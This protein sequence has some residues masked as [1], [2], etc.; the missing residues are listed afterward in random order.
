MSGLRRPRRPLA[1]VGVVLITALAVVPSALAAVK[2]GGVDS[3]NFPSLRVTVVT[4]KGSK[5][6]TLLE[7]GQPV[8]GASAVNLGQA[9]TVVVAIDRSESMKGRPISNAVAAAQQFVRTAGPQDHIGVVEFGRSAITVQGASGSAADAATSLQSVTVDTKSGTS[10]Y[11]AVVMSANLLKQDA[12]A[13]RAII[14][15]T[16]GADVSSLHTLADAVAA[17]HRAHASIYSIGIGGPSFTPDALRSLAN[18]T[19]GSYRQAANSAAL[20]SVYASLTDEL[21]RTWQITYP[22]AA[23]PGSRVELTASVKGGG[24]ST[25]TVTL[26]GKSAAPPTQASPVIPSAGYSRLGTLLVSL[27]VAVLVFLAHRAWMAAREGHWLGRRLEPHLMTSASSAEKRSK[28]SGES[29]RKRLSDTIEA[30]FANVKQ[31]RALQKKIER[32]NIQWR[33]GELLAF[34]VGIGF[35][36]GLVF[37]VMFASP[38]LGLVGI[39]AGFFVPI[40]VVTFK[41][42]SRLKKFENQLPD[43]LITMAASLKAGHSFRQG[44]QSVVEEGAEPAAHEFKRVLHETQLG[45]PMDNALADMAERVG[46]DNLSFVVTSVTIQR[47]IGGS[48]AG[49]FDMVADTVRQR[50]QFARKIKGLTAMGRMSAYVLVGLPFFMAALVTLMNPSY[51]SPLYHT[52][53]GHILCGVTLVMMGLGSLMLKKIVSFRG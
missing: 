17:A 11:D 3:S 32:A 39:V 12:G 7:N 44:V 28:G 53:A 31:F 18:D 6:P 25:S 49:L 1:T 15:V 9:K 22:T 5:A 46:S 38:L 33:A 27:A 52:G 45:K 26:A 19:G 37:A 35:V 21:A 50:Q 24:H 42:N 34:C 41:A 2:I 48:L 23:R 13:G 29:A 14:V 8:V 30:A 10:L 47:Q 43:L 20:K 40:L 51:M 16:D 36:T 4:P